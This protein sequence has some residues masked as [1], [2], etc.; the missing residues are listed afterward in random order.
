MPLSP[1]L[2][3]ALESPL[4]CALGGQLTFLRTPKKNQQTTLEEPIWFDTPPKDYKPKGG[5]RQ[6]THKNPSSGSAGDGRSGGG[7]G[8]SAQVIMCSSFPRPHSR[9]RT[10]RENPWGQGLDDSF[11][12]GI[13]LYSLVFRGL[14]VGSTG[15]SG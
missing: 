12:V 4:S 6:K 10:Q 13:S 1:T 14:V 11:C 9:H 3:P 8:G 2:L 15:L 7:G 5:K